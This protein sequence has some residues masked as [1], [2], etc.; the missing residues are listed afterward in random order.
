MLH[1]VT[2]TDLARMA[3]TLARGGMNP[4]TGRRV[5]DAASGSA[6]AQR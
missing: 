4:V 3:A 6:H 5:I 1:Q 2:S